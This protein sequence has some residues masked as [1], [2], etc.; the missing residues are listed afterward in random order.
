MGLNY[1]TNNQSSARE[2]HAS[3]LDYSLYIVI[4]NDFIVPELVCKV[5]ISGNC[6]MTSFVQLLLYSPQKY[7]IDKRVTYRLDK[8]FYIILE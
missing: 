1:L 7:L 8:F 3:V 2:V 5:I 6:V 4:A